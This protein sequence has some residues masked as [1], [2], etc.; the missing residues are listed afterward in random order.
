M[1]AEAPEEQRAAWLK[2]SPA[3]RLGETWELKGVRMISVLACGTVKWGLKS[4]AEFE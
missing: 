1:L 2:N 3:G 4:H